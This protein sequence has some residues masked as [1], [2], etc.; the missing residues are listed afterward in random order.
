MTLC[1]VAEKIDP[2][3]EFGLTLAEVRLMRV[4]S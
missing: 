3:A 1:V 2:D 4:E